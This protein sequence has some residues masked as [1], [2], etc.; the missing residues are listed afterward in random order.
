MWNYPVENRYDIYSNCGYNVIG[1]QPDQ[2]PLCYMNEA[3]E[4]CLENMLNPLIVQNMPENPGNYIGDVLLR[5]K[6]NK[7]VKRDFNECNSQYDYCDSSTEPSTKEENYCELESNR[8]SKTSDNVNKCEEFSKLSHNYKQAVLYEGSAKNGSDGFNEKESVYQKD[9]EEIYDNLSPNTTC[10][11]N[12]MSPEANSHHEVSNNTYDYGNGIYSGLSYDPWNVRNME[13]ASLNQMNSTYFWEP[14]VMNNVY[15]N[16]YNGMGQVPYDDI[17]FNSS[18]SGIEPYNITQDPYTLN[19]M[20]T[21]PSTIDLSSTFNVPY[22]NIYSPNE[23]FVSPSIKFQPKPYNNFVPFEQNNFFT[24]KNLDSQHN[25]FNKSKQFKQNYSKATLNGTQVTKNSNNRMDLVTKTI[26]GDNQFNSN[27]IDE[28]TLEGLIYNGNIK[29]I[30]LGSIDFIN[31][32]D[33]TWQALRGAGLFKLGN[34]GR[35]VLKSK[36]SKHLKMYPELRM[37][38]S[39]ISGVRRATTRQ[40]FQLAQICQITSH[41]R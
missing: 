4:H 13:N 5:D 27:F 1:T 9:K 37:R 26:K 28:D 29:K 17:G 20:K 35:A 40:L 30:D 7:S 23:A 38:T 39:C 11:T 19:F 32:S 3:N 18:N 22:G 16:G 36:I 10:S 41:L 2:N 34:K 14:N 8:G 15:Y 25:F 6:T 21:A 33:R 12:D 24:N 31:M